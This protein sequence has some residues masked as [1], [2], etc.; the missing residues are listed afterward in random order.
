MNKVIFLFGIVASM[1]FLAGCSPRYTVEFEPNGGV[2]IEPQKVE[3]ESSIQVPIAIREG[4]TLEGWYTSLN[5][6]QTLDEKWSFTNN[7]V[8]NDI[9]LYAN[10]TIN[11]YT[12]S[13]DTDG[14]TQMSSITQEYNTPISPIADP[15]KAGYSFTGWSE[16]IPSS[17]PA[18]NVTMSAQWEI[19]EY[20]I[21]YKD[22]DGT[23]ID[24]FGFEYFDSVENAVVNP[25]TREGY[26]F[27]E[28]SEPL[29]GRMPAK[30]IELEAQLF[31]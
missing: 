29:P 20:S 14:G 10:W 23:V 24:T 6:G 5:N 18:K 9:T 30:N 8:N 1:F 25:P 4:Y 19:N 26:I 13:F 15:Y 17:M 31:V 11:Q 2:E 3:G 21:T 7:N 27:T 12:P 22:Y 28:W 16:E